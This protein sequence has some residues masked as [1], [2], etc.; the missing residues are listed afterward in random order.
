MNA[1]L[2]IFYF[3]FSFF[4]WQTTKRCQE[5]ESRSSVGDE[6]L[7]SLNWPMRFTAA[8]NSQNTSTERYKRIA[9]KGKRKRHCTTELSYPKQQ[10]IHASSI[11]C[12]FISLLANQKRRENIARSQSGKLMRAF[13]LYFFFNFVLVRPHFVVLN[14]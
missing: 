7:Q 4:L 10:R 2:A 3:H 1:M 13:S 12:S 9:T 14:C 6:K 8:R 11:F 5:N